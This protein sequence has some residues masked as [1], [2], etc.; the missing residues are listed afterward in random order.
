MNKKP[1]III[2][3]PASGAA[4]EE[5][6]AAIEASLALQDAAY[7]I[8]ETTSEMGGRELAAK[9]VNEGATHI[10]ACGGDGTVMAVVN[11]IGETL[12]EGAEPHVT[13]SIIPRGTANLLAAALGIPTELEAAIE[14]AIAGRERVID[15]GRCGDYLFALGLGLGLTERFVARSSAHDKEKLGVYAY[16]RALFQELGARPN[17]F[18]FTLDDGVQRHNRGV[19]LGVLNVGQMGSLAVAPDAKMDNGL[20]DIF[21]L[22]RFYL[23]DLMRIVGRILVGKINEDRAITFHQA[24]RFEINSDPPLDLQIDGEPVD[25][26]TPLVV[27]VL[28]RALRVRI[29]N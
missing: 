11:G 15:L 8:L 7:T 20:L 13:M 14:V 5:P 28:P 12:V 27:E 2:L 3:N 21:I 26:K 29:P 9:A 16:A 17:T 10:V 23:R 19:A 1:M 18:S 6:R 4:G 22:H 24:R 25:L